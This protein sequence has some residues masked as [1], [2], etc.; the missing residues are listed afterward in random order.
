L[1]FMLPLRSIKNSKF[2]G[3]RLASIFPVVTQAPSNGGGP[4]LGTSS[5]ATIA[6]PAIGGAGTPAVSLVPPAGGDAASGTLS[7]PDAAGPPLAHAA[8]TTAQLHRQST[9][10][11]QI[12]PD[13][14]ASGFAGGQM[15]I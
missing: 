2:A 7:D 8:S 9:M 1:Q 14:E 5:L 6:G 4:A 11:P 10:D 3:R 12:S 13:G 15:G